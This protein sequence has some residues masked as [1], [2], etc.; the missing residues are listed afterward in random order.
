MAEDTMTS[1]CGFGVA[2]ETGRLVG[3][4][5]VVCTGLGVA[6]GVLVEVDVGLEVGDKVIPGVTMNRVQVTERDLL[7]TSECLP[8]PA[9]RQVAEHIMMRMPKRDT[10][11]R[12]CNEHYVLPIQ[13]ITR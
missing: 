13:I 2:V 11:A 3:V 1:S 8:Q 4:G 12:P 9:T 7:A 10:K 5:R 6:D